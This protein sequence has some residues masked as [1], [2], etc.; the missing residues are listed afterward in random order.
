MSN[1]KNREELANR[2]S[3]LFEKTEVFHTEV[4]DAINECVEMAN[5]AESEAERLRREVGDWISRG[6]AYEKTIEGLQNQ[7]S[8]MRQAEYAATAREL[9]LQS[10]STHQNVLFW[11]MALVAVINLVMGILS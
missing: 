5:R 11:L 9:K 1:H 2:V 6:V 4:A 10:R 8:T 7:A 3:L